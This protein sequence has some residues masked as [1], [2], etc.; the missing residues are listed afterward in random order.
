MYTELKHPQLTYNTKRET[1]C[2]VQAA[3]VRLDK[4]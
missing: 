2:D 3:V 1:G 4:N